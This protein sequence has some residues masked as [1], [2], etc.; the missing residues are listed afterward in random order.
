MIKLDNI[1]I[2]VGDNKVY[3]QT[4]LP[5]EKATIDFINE[6]SKKINDYK[7]INNFPDLQSAAFF[8]RKAN[9]LNLKK[10]NLINNQLRVG[11]GLLFHVAPANAPTNF[12]YSL[13][14][15]LLTGNSNIVKVSS[16]KFEQVE[17]ICLLIN[18]LLKKYKKISTFIKIIRYDNVNDEIT[19]K[20]SKLS[21]ARIIW[22]GDKTIESI[23]KFVLKNRAVDISFADRY[24]ACFINSNKFINLSENKKK[25]LINNFYNDTFTLDQNACSSPHLIFWYGSNIKRNKDLFW[26]LLADI[27]NKRYNLQESSAVNKYM[28]IC[29]NLI[30]NDNIKELKNYNNNIYTLLLKKLK[31][32]I[33]AYRG[34]WGYFYEYN[35]NNFQE[36]KKINTEKIQ[37][38]TY[39]G[40]SKKELEKIILNNSPKGIDRVVPIGQAL[41]IDFIWDGY[42]IYNF[43]T[44]TVDIK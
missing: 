31:N 4:K 11:R 12:L 5:F 42:D 29:K 23:K 33:T 3:N 19:K 21:D 44:R 20:I 1:K 24:S 39:F 17:I 38:I 30:Q 40:F 34:Q 13:I 8:C 26:T 18:K 27:A 36:L 22:G 28:Q 25:L 7:Y 43:L 6:L 15:G 32:D 2:L 41:D 16:K 10:K 14:F 9:L 37:T 35:L